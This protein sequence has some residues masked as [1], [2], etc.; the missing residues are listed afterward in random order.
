MRAPRLLRT[1]PFRLTLLFLA[2][3][4]AAACAF[5]AYIYLAT[6]GEV[7]GRADAQVSREMHSLE[8]VYRRGGLTALNQAVIER[9][10]GDRALLYLLM[11]NHGAPIS[12][13]GEFRA[14][15]DRYRWGGDASTRTRAGG[16]HARRR[17]P[18]RR[19]RRKR[20]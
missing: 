20:V 10:S 13:L 19:R 6:A 3:F 15:A 11:D 9:S 4:A 16:G 14:D 1:T 2:L 17:T 7:T 5:L 18:V 12:D 8:A